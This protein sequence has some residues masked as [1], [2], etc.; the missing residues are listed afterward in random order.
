VSR[1]RERVASICD[2]A[3]R[4]ES[5]RGSSAFLTGVIQIEYNAWH[6]AQSN[7]WVSLTEAVFAGLHAALPPSTDFAAERELGRFGTAVRLQKEA[8][9]RRVSASKVQED[10]ASELKEA[11]T[12]YQ[13]A[14]QEYATHVADTKNW[15]QIGKRFLDKV[16]SAA[17]DRAG[18]TLGHQK[19]SQRPEYLFDTLEQARTVGGR[20]GLLTSAA[21]ARQYVGNLFVVPLGLLALTGIAYVFRFL[22]AGSK[23][24]PDWFDAITKG[25]SAATGI[26]AV[27][28][29]FGVLFLRNNAARALNKLQDFELKLRQSIR[30]TEQ[31]NIYQKTQAEDRVALCRQEVSESRGRLAQSE[32]TLAVLSLQNL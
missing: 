14:L 11:E 6:N 10:A 32:R 7:P 4:D 16:D 28:M 18:V 3:R 5:S 20:A 22:Y 13:R 31:E 19:L 30:E 25:F 21:L 23:S 26:V 27:V 8:E 1:L 24:L 12:T 17:I 29:F 2:R 15:D 9:L